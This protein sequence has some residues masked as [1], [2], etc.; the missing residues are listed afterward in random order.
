MKMR[1]ASIAEAGVP[2][3][4]VAV[5][6]YF[7]RAH[8]IECLRTLQADFPTVAINLRMTT[9]Q[10]GERLV[11]EGTCA[12]AVTITDVPELSP[13]TIERQHLCEARM[14]TVC[15]PSHPLAAIAGPIPRE[16][17]GRHI[18]LVVTD[19][20][21]DAEKTQQGVASERQWRVNDLGAKHDLL[22]G[23]LCWGH[24]PHHIVAE[25]LVNGSLVELQRRAWHMRPLT[26]VVSQRRGYSFSECETRLVE[27]LGDPRRLPKDGSQRSVST[28]GNKALR[29]ATRKRRS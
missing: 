21:P 19:N 12:L 23:S 24:M 7:A 6:T 4:S 29:P 28:K 8:L 1:A 5:D 11:L 27:L 22:K 18:Q 16:E 20:Q 3:V 17:F 13:A 9:M 15:A 25:D 10:G 14:V 2:Q 26:F